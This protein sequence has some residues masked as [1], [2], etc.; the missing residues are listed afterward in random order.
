MMMEDGGWDGP[1]EDPFGG[2]D[3]PWLVLYC[4]AVDSWDGWG[5]S[6]GTI[7]SSISIYL[8]SLFSILYSL[9][10]PPV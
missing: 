7:Y 6:V 4:A 10:N 8:Y 9:R 2:D 1:G 5:H 3:L